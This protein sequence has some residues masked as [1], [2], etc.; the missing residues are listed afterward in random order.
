MIR[1]TVPYKKYS[2][3]WNASP[4][5]YSAGENIVSPPA[6]IIYVEFKFFSQND[7]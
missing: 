2:G 3:S 7:K 4:A 5:I 6:S 1:V